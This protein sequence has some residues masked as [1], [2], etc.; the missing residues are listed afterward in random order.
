MDTAG[1]AAPDRPPRSAGD[2]FAAR[3]A[4]GQQRTPAGG[5][6]FVEQVGRIKGVAPRQVEGHQSRDAGRLG[7]LAAG[8]TGQMRMRGGA[9]GVG[10][11]EGGFQEQGVGFSGQRDQPR[12][13]VD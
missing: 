6:D 3:S 10:L 4:L 1:T 13:V 2:Y 7:D 12:A 9:R 11:S 5:P 8:A